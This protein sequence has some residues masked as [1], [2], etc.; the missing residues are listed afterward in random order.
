MHVEPITFC[1]RARAWRR[2]DSDIVFRRPA[3]ARMHR[4][5]SLCIL[6][7]QTKQ[8]KLVHQFGKSNRSHSNRG[9]GRRRRA[10]P[11]GGPHVRACVGIQVCACLHVCPSQTKLSS[12]CKSLRDH[13]SMPTPSRRVTWQSAAAR[14]GTCDARPGHAPPGQS[15]GPAVTGRCRFVEK[16]AGRSKLKIFALAMPQ[17]S[18]ADSLFSSCA[19]LGPE[20]SCLIMLS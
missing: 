13:I 19:R 16:K 15:T 18:H 1:P 2:G 17:G 12:H 20:F 3:R 7:C 8:D 11:D 4:S 6:T 9:P 10:R 5:S 14:F